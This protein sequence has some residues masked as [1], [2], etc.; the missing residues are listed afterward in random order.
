MSITN[1]YATLGELKRYLGIDPT[2]TA[3]TISFT[4]G[5]KT[6]ADSALGLEA[7]ATG[8]KVTVSGSTSND[9]T[10]TVATGGTAASFTTT[11]ALG[12]DEAAGDTVTITDISNRKDD[13]LLETLIEAASRGIDR[14]TGRRFYAETKTR[15]YEMD[16]VDGDYLMLDDDLL[17]ITTLTNGDDSSTTIS[18]SYYWLW[19]R[20]E[21]PYW[22]IRLK[23]SQTT[24]DWE[25][26]S[27]YFI[28]VA[29][30]WGWAATCPDD[31]KHA[32]IRYAAFLYHQKD[33]GVYDVS[34]FPDSG[35]ITT[36]Q[37]IPRDVKLLLARYVRGP[38]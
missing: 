25:R 31:V 1:G 14:H 17:T 36:P 3:I 38:G 9:G 16:A 34:V 30:T 11:E 12:G 26:D 24:Y 5:T 20:N 29:G 2:Y 21:T 23:D 32:C 18:S 27:G 6:I 15:Y 22:A 7:F 35:V 37:G 8:A 33:S 19:P 4:A 28:S 10:Y 13:P